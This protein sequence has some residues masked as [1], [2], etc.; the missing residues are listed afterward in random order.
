[1]TTDEAVQ[2]LG[3]LSKADRHAA[4]KEY[5]RRGQ[6]F[7]VEYSTSGRATCRGCRRPIPKDDIRIRH[8]VCGRKCF[9]EKRTGA[10]DACG[11][12]H[13]QYGPAGPAF[14]LGWPLTCLQVLRRR[15][16]DGRG[17]V[18]DDERVLGGGAPPRSVSGD[19]R[20]V[21]QRSSAS[22]GCASRRRRRGGGRSRRR[23]PAATTKRETQAARQ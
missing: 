13:L 16:D 2:T 14:V 22:C 18:Q 15:A 3:A 4:Y 9:L 5:E 21:R 10:A 8:I 19:G 1:M 7:C 20:P 12:W 23:Q 6:L 11:R 17:P